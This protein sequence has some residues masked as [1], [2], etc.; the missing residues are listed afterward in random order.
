MQFVPLSLPG[1][2]LIEEAPRLDDRGMFLK[3]F[4]I[5]AFESAGLAVR[6]AE[7]YFTLSKKGVLRGMHFQVPPYD[8]AKVASCLS[9]S[10]FDVV[11]DLR[12]GSPTFGKAESVVLDRDGHCQIYIAPGIAHGFYALTDDVLMYYRVTSLYAPQY[13][14][15][16]QWRSVPVVWPNATPTLSVRDAGFPAIEDFVSPFRYEG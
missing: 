5:D 4:Q 9:G 2:F 12:V 14:M 16:V 15:G 1:C 3:T 6:F 13:D 10:V 11:L 8:H 7:E